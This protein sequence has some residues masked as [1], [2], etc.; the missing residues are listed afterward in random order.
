MSFSGPVTSVTNA[1]GFSPKTIPGM[2]SRL[3]LGTGLFG[4]GQFDLVYRSERITLY[5]ND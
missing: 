1:L 2:I 5:P 4:W 3:L